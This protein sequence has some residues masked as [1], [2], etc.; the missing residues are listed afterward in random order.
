[1]NRISS[2]S[3]L[4]WLRNR[5]A[6]MEVFGNITSSSR[7]AQ[8][9]RIL[10]ALR[11]DKRVRAVVLDIDSPGG[12]AALSDHLHRALA[13]VDERKP[14]IA[15][16]R[17][18][19]L[20]G[21]YLVICAARRIVA[22]PTATIGSIGVIIAKPIV[23]DLMS[24]MGVQMYVSRVGE[25]KDMLQPWREPTP[26]EEQKLADLRD[27]IYEWFIATVSRTRGLEE[28]RVRSYATGEIFTAARGIDMG[29]VDELGDMDTA[30]DMASE[31]GRVPRV[32][33][34]VRPRR[35]LF[36]RLLAPVGSAMADRVLAAVEARL[37]FR[38]E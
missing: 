30:L 2:S 34:Y 12:S 36:E 26:E 8:Q 5:I 37:R 33:A 3:N 4:P 13:S 29:L 18:V 31:M 22:L 25:H 19:A 16:V 24:R 32:L 21:G 11:E 23:R 10:H 27:E 17:N 14:V 7:V 15:H 20:S 35:P 6:V 28:D 1:M 38:V 9:V